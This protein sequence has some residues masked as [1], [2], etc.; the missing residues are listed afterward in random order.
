MH[1]RCST[2]NKF[3]LAFKM[4]PTI[5]IGPGFWTKEKNYY[6]MLV[7]RIFAGMPKGQSGVRQTGYQSRTYFETSLLTRLI[8]SRART[9]E[10]KNNQY[11][12]EDAEFNLGLH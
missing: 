11:P 6:L 3:E 9:A 1:F 7:L 8:K 4:R 2:R 12:S 5:K 10:I